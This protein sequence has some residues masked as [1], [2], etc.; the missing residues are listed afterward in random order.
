M[1]FIYV[2]KFYKYIRN[3]FIWKDPLD[4]L[5]IFEKVERE[6]RL[7]EAKKKEK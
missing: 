2:I 5:T 7:R 6:L 4:H 1:G 3:K